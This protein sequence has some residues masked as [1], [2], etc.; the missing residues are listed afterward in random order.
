MNKF[1]FF[2]LKFGKIYKIISDRELTFVRI[3]VYFILG[4]ILLF[5]KSGRITEGI[6]RK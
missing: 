3:L 1:H 4:Q 5:S 6:S 2:S